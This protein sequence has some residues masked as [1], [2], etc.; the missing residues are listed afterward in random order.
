MLDNKTTEAAD[1][2]NKIRSEGAKFLRPYTSYV[3]CFRIEF[4]LFR[5]EYPFFLSSILHAVRVTYRIRV[6]IRVWN[7]RE[8]SAPQYLSV[9]R[10]TTDV[11]CRYV[12]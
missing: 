10:M 2:P 11:S 1:Y 12:F 5:F 6:K 4:R 3:Q 7:R 8:I 9:Y